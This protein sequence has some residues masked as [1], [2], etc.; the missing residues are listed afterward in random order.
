[1]STTTVA[2]RRRETG[3]SAVALGVAGVLTWLVADLVLSPGLG[4]VLGTGFVLTS[5][6]L[7]LTIRHGD[8]F[9]AGVLPPLLLGGVLLLTAVLVGSELEGASVLAR[10]V[11]ALVE[12][13]VALVLGWVGSL[14]VLLVRGSRPAAPPR[15]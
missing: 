13:R 5:L 7:A 3:P 8:F 14:A 10:T 12:Q 2:L 4:A 6:W 9:V 1:M 11:G 15:P